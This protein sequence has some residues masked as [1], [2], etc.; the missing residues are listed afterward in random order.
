MLVINLLGD[1][2]AGPPHPPA[3]EA[4]TRLKSIKD[5]LTS[6]LFSSN[7]IDCGNGQTEPRCEI[8]KSAVYDGPSINRTGFCGNRKRVA[9]LT[10][11][12][13]LS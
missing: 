4:V 10:K 13:E 9:K 11:R 5:R 7:I 8:L 6:H 2:V 12:G 1:F 3:I